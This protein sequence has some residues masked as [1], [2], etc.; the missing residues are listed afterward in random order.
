MVSER[1]PIQSK[2]CFIRLSFKLISFRLDVL[3]LHINVALMELKYRDI[4]VTIDRH[5]AFDWRHERIN[6]D[7]IEG[8]IDRI[9][10]FTEYNLRK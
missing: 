7:T 9:W 2:E 4:S 3:R 8:A 5:V 6:H 1:I 10:Y